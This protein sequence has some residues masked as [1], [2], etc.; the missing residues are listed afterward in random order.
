MTAD[1]VINIIVAAVVQITP[2]PNGQ[3]RI[4]ANTPVV[5]SPTIINC[6]GV[7]LP[8]NVICDTTRPVTITA[9]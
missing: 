3:I 9:E 8:T 4:V 7:W 1:I 6:V 2:L 5:L